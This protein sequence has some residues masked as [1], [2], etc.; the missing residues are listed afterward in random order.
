VISLQEDCNLIRLNDSVNITTFTCGHDD[1][2]D[3][4]K[5]DAKGYMDSLLSVTYLF[6]HKTSGQIIAFFS[7]SNNKLSDL[8]NSKVRNKL[9]R[10]VPYPKRRKDYPAVLIGRLGVCSEYAR[11]GIGSVVLDF[12]KGWFRYEN[13]TGC[14][15]ILVDAYNEEK[16]LKFYLKNGFD[17]L[18]ESDKAAQTRSMYFDLKR[19]E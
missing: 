1:L 6:I 2:D 14:K 5:S 12:I 7:V 8:G 4:I 9:G 17:F 10:K 15:F 13:K 3:F 18:I 19:L 16:V 11:H